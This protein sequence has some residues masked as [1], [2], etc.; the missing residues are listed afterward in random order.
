MNPGWT[1]LLGL[2]VALCRSFPCH[3]AVSGDVNADGRV[4]LADA[5][6]A[7]QWT[8]EH[9][10]V[11]ASEL[12][13]ADV[14][15]DGRVTVADVQRLLRRALGLERPPA[16]DLENHAWTAFAAGPSSPIYSL[17]F[18]RD[19][20]TLWAAAAGQNL[21]H[22]SDDGA[23]WKAA[24]HSDPF[25]FG[26]FQTSTAQKA[27]LAGT[28]QGVRIS[29]DGGQTWADSPVLDDAR[30]GTVYA[31]A[32]DPRLPKRVYAAGDGLFRSDDGGKTWRAL[33]LDL[34]PL[35]DIHALATDPWQPGRALVGTRQGRILHSEDGGENWE[36]ADE[37]EAG[38]G[39]RIFAFLPD[40][41]R[42]DRWYLGSCNG[43][44]WR[45]DDGGLHWVKVGAD[46]LPQNV[47]ALLADSRFPGRI[48]AGTST[49]P[50]VSEDSGDAWRPLGQG[51]LRYEVLSLSYG[52]TESTLY[53][54]TWTA[55][56]G[57]HMLE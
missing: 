57:V 54:G 49:G 55:E 51:L 27:I 28:F 9:P 21:Y 32:S 13:S 43:G 39:Y 42:K 12:A 40:A 53:A 36:E 8:L 52:P 41:F 3:A 46:T 47:N 26:L 44:M 20:R 45:S 19:T 34:N 16:N 50:F 56:I 29:A 14:D 11:D 25:V 15:G 4:D 35:E 2:C 22:S 31:F 23:T 33:P 6:Q 48:Y 1:T 10:S 24:F 30:M 37:G 18:D 5:I 7:L 17:L 38:F